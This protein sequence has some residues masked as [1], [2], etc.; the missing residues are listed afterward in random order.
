MKYRHLFE[1]YR[2]Q[3]DHIEKHPSGITL[4]VYKDTRQVTAHKGTK[5]IGAT[6][7]H[8]ASYNKNNNEVYKTEVKPEF[9]KQGVATA[10]YQTL[11]KH[12]G[13]IKPSNALSDDGFNFWKKYR[14]N[15]VKDSL[16]MHREHLLGKTVDH[17]TDA[18]FKDATIHSVGD[19]GVT[20]KK[21]YGPGENDYA[22]YHIARKHIEH[23]L[24]KDNK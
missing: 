16:R 13:E 21:H 17:P 10:M 2:P 18:R 11:E 19:N 9:R 7:L 8:M 23:L 12:F 6:I 5:T 15:A 20:I 22:T 14:P 1:K 24:P 4:K 3:P